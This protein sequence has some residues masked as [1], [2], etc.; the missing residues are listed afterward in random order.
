MSRTLASFPLPNLFQFSELVAQADGAFLPAPTIRAVTPS[1]ATAG[2][3]SVSLVL[4][5]VNFVPGATVYIAGTP[6]FTSYAGPSQLTATLPASGLAV[7]GTFPITIANPDSVGATSNPINFVVQPTPSGPTAHFTATAQGQSVRD[8]GS[9]SLSAPQGGSVTVSG[10]STS[11]PRSAPIATYGWMSNGTPT[12]SSSS[13]CTFSFATGKDTITLTVTDSSGRSSTA[14]AIVVVSVGSAPAA[15]FT[16]T[17]QQQSAGDAGTLNLVVP[18]NGSVSVSL[19]ASGSTAG[20][21]TIAGY[22]WT[23]NGTTISTESQFTYFFGTPG[24]TVALTITNGNGQTATAAAQIK[25]TI[26]AAPNPVVSMTAQGQGAVGNNGALKVSVP[27]NGSVTVNFEA[28]GST[29]GSG[30]ITSYQWT[31]NGT[32]ISTQSS[33]TYS[34]GISTNAIALTITNSNGQSGTAAAYI[35]VTAQGA[36]GPAV[37]TGSPTSITT[38]SAT[39]GGTVNPNGLDTHFWFLY[40]TRHLTQRGQPDPELRHGLGHQFGGHQRQHRWAD[41]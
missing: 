36:S 2:G 41:R 33:F 30:T 27:P 19:S 4:T 35:N 31:S 21:G 5:G 20:S 22:Q 24:N 6:L 39:F 16:M 40:G 37:S 9:L 3:P 26:E 10:E 15:H 28:S 1:A 7:P 25:V 32:T 23:G 29:A 17:A 34:F 12:C 11:S 38:N 8:G 13:L 18:Q 14:T